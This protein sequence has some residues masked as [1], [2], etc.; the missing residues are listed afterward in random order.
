MAACL[1]EIIALQ[2]ACI[3]RQGYYQP[4]MTFIVVQSGTTLGFSRKLTRIRLDEAIMFSL[5][6]MVDPTI[7]QPSHLDF[8][9]Y[10]NIAIQGTSLSGHYHILWDDINFTADELQCFSYQLCHMFWRCNRS[11]SYP[12]LIYYDHHDAEH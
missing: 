4:K 10:S 8:Y 2:K 12:V 11:V 1:E 6:T 7:T 3:E 9:L 5:G